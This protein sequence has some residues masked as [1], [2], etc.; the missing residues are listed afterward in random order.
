MEGQSL[1]LPVPHAN[2]FGVGAARRA[3]MEGAVVKT[4]RSSVPL[5]G[6]NSLSCRNGG[7]VVKTA[8]YR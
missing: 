8:R 2:F 3:A 6:N 4:A 1:R 7:A 5:I